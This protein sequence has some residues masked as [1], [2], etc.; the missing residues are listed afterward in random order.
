MENNREVKYDIKEKKGLSQ[1]ELE[2]L[3]SVW[4]KNLSWMTGS[5]I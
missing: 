3:L 5:L 2:T 4:Q 1:K